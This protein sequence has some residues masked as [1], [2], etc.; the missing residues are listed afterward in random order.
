MAMSLSLL[1]RRCC[2][3]NR[4]ALHRL[5]S[6]ASTSESSDDADIVISGGGMVGASM[7]CALAYSD[8][9]ADKRIVLLEAAP[10][11]GDF[12]LPKRYSN[13]TCALSPSTAGLLS[14]FGAWEEIEMMRSQP[15]RRMQVWDSCSDSM[16]AFS[17]EDMTEPLAWIV[18]NDVILGAIMRRL[19]QA[20]NPVDIR[21]ET[22]AKSF[23]IP[24]VS[25]S[26]EEKSKHPWVKVELGGEKSIYTRLLVGA[27]G[28]K[29][30]V[31]AA[32]KLHTVK[33]NYE[34]TAV[35]A[36]LR[37]AEAIDN[38]VAWQR[39]LPTGPIALL[40][41][42]EEFSSLVW[43]T[44][45][46][47]AKHLLKLPEESFVDAVNDAYWHERDKNAL[48][49][50][51]VDGFSQLLNNIMPGGTAMKQLP[52]TVTGVEEKSRAAFPLELMH[53]SHYVRPRV[54]LIGDAAHRLHPLAGQ[55]VNL[56]FGDVECL[57]RILEQ[58]VAGG[59]DLGSLNHLLTYETKRQ[60]HN[61]PV[62]ATIDGLQRLYST[63]FTPLVVARSLGLT[64]VNSLTMFKN[65]II[66]RATA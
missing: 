63:D 7:A 17:Q 18:E 60:R 4:Q 50:K 66:Q 53:A 58:A 38:N 32:A 16:I 54:A 65:L 45:P 26:W 1:F 46:E 37:L 44:T 27:D 42:S 13:R 28:S 62:V 21:F 61:L 24:H 30:A 39:F 40:P 6:T 12:H 48:A 14:S 31:R 23:V 22:S 49:D 56:G 57:T 2:P 25:E 34:Q 15:V 52:P 43:T 59:S 9:F 3:K 41:L 8:S 10:D 5:F 35:V 51:A 29:S 47:D 55:G 36:T 11:R 19:R 20:P 33:W 64:A